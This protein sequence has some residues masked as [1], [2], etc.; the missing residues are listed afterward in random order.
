MNDNK[1]LFEYIKNHDWAKFTDLL[2]KKKEIDVNIRDS[3]YNYLIQY[4]IMFNKKDIVTYLI[5][6]GCRLDIIDTDGRSI[7]F[8]PIKFNYIDILELLLHFNNN[9]I[10]ISLIDIRDNYGFTALYYSIMFNNINAFDILIKN[11][12]DLRIKNKKSKDGIHLAV[13]YKRI[14]ILRKILEQQ[15]NIN[16][17][18]NNGETALHYA[19]NYNYTEIA[20]LLIYN[21]ANINIQDY[22]QKATPLIYSVALANTE[23]TNLLLK[24]KA[25]VNLQDH[26]G[27]TALH[28]A[29]IDNFPAII[30]LLLDKDDIDYNIVNLDGNTSLH[31]ALENNIDEDIIIK[32]IKNTNLNIQNNLGNT[33]LYY[34]IK[35]ELWELSRVLENK[36]CNFFIRNNKNE[37]IIDIYPK[38]SNEY[39]KLLDIATES[40]YNM[41]INNDSKWKLKWEK[42]CQKNS[43][44]NKNELQKIFKLKDNNQK[45]ICKKVIIDYIEKNNTSIPKIEDNEIN[46]TLDN[47]IIVKNCSYTGST[48][49]VIMGLLY[50]EKKFNSCK[51]A[52][53]NNIIENQDVDEYYQSLG[54]VNDFKIEFLNFEILW[55]YQKLLYPNNFDETVNSHLKNN[56][57]DFIVIP[58]GIEQENGS[59]ANILFWDIKKNEVERFEPNGSSCPYQLN[60][61]PQLLDQ[62]I[63]NKLTCFNKKLKYFP[64]DTYLP[65]LG[66][67]QFEIQEQAMCARIGD[68]NGFCA[69]WCN[70]WVDMHITYNTLCRNRL[71]YKLFKKIR[72][73]NI[74]FKNLI[75]NYSKNIT[76]LRDGI[77]EKV[78][79]DIN[80]WINETYTEEQF[81]KL[82][83]LIYKMIN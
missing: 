17:I 29:I 35:L 60:Y 52:L 13:Q 69:I 70:W 14:E 78:N 23:I 43:G 3:N 46:I 55:I 54:I 73:D 38:K 40:Y 50:L 16:S 1:T 53:S 74:R 44:E 77:L 32:L 25:L 41:I 72:E 5:N 79:L 62:L 22:K 28:L 61:N 49:D 24:K 27:N 76:D 8:I 59:H 57:I 2:K 12:S 65:V 26:F 10:G 67:Q 15:I 37:I 66:F 68:P 82:T 83:E 30:R 18:D 45:N 80:D 56:K 4:I 21:N 75:R 42:L 71:V 7:L 11:G 39:K 6:R 63:R 34:I 36:K 47:G 64:P 51:T 20:K 33:S 9:V 81:D 19:C 48:I 31:I 58:I